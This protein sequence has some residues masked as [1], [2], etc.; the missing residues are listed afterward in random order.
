[1]GWPEK[2]LSRDTKR[3]PCGRGKVTW[4][5]NFWQISVNILK[6]CNI[7]IYLQWETNRKW[8]IA[9]QM[10]ATAMTLN[11]LKGHS[12]VACLFKC[13]PSNI[14]VAFYRI[15]TD[16][17]LARFLC[18]SRA[19]CYLFVHITVS[20]QHGIWQHMNRTDK[21]NKRLQNNSHPW[22]TADEVAHPVS[23]LSRFKIN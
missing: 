9:Y 19:S 3:S 7:E 22:D 20:Q 16:S 18:I 14:C 11:D 4:R 17:V 15:S 5:L 2:C 21:A 12:Q 13:N 8:Y 10:I 1:M 23:L 6:R